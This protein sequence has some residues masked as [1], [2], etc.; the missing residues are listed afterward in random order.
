MYKRQFPK[1]KK[2][3]T[4]QQASQIAAA[5]LFPNFKG[6]L[7]IHKNHSPTFITVVFWY[8]TYSIIKWGLSPF[9]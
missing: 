4:K 7:W 8:K 1:E 2:I 3:R 9:T 6:W 5:M